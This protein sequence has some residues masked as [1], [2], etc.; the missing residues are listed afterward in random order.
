MGTVI[1][2]TTGSS[3]N[4]VAPDG[5]SNQK[6]EVL[7]PVN[8]VQ[9]PDFAAAIDID[10]TQMSTIVNAGDLTGD[11]TINLDINEK[12]TGGAILI[13]QLTAS[14]ATRTVTLGTG[15]DGDS[16]SITDGAT[17]N[18]MA[19]F[20]GTSFK[21]VTA[22]NDS[23]QDGA[24]T[25]AKLATDAVETTKIK[26]DAVTS[27]KIADD[28]VTADH[29]HSDAVETAAIKDKNVTLAKLEDGTAGDILVF[30]AQ[31]WEKLPKG[32]DG[33]VLKMV[34]G[35]PAWAADAIE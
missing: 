18:V 8:E 5:A 10:I 16:V 21:V 15:I 14:G 20:D 13:L 33:Q 35:A 28:A 17:V 27:D 1:N 24:I 19:I 12:V 34:A 3:F 25:A 6:V 29:L 2:T 26:N 30:T 31:G 9:T 32:N 4:F 23:V 22:S 7:F 11:A